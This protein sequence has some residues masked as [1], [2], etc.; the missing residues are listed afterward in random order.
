MFLLLLGK[1]KFF[2]QTFKVGKCKYNIVRNG[3]VKHLCDDNCFKRFRSSPTTYLK[4]AENA[5]QNQSKPETQSSSAPA[6]TP[7][8]NSA[9]VKATPNQQPSF[10]AVGFR[11]YI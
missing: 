5:T 1:L 4:Q 6:P 9:P 10:Q 3:D 8:K 11:K 2:F 7:V